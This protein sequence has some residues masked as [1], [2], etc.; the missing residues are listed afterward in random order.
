MLTSGKS[1]NGTKN[2]VTALLLDVRTIHYLHQNG[3]IRKKGDEGARAEK[4]GGKKTIPP[5]HA[6]RQGCSI[7]QPQKIF[8]GDGRCECGDNVAIRGDRIKKEECQEYGDPRMN[9]GGFLETSQ[10]M[11]QKRRDEEHTQGISAKLQGEIEEGDRGAEEDRG[12]GRGGGAEEPSRSLVTVHQGHCRKERLY[13]SKYDD[14]VKG[15]VNIMDADD[16]QQTGNDDIEKDVVVGIQ[17]FC[18]GDDKS[19]QRTLGERTDLIPPEVFI[20]I[21]RDGV[22]KGGDTGEDTTQTKPTFS[23]TR[24]GS[25]GGGVTRFFV[26]GIVHKAKMHSEKQGINDPYHHKIS[27]SYFRSGDYL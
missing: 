8:N 11:K 16:P 17:V 21:Y 14:S 27:K 4:T 2:R 15:R 5:P 24:T 10:D 3:R 6:S 26:N 20:Y 22:Y 9:T 25:N 13:R 18:N 12:D 1:E 23:E 19:R 7:E